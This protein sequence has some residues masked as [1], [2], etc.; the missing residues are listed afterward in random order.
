MITKKDWD[1]I[2]RCVANHPVGIKGD[3]AT[4]LLKKM[5]ILAAGTTTERTCLDS[6]GKLTKKVVIEYDDQTE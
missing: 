1:M 6:Y 4:A 5:E 3:D 2:A